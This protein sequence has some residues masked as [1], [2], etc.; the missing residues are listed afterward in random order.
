SVLTARLARN[1]SRNKGLLD[2]I[3]TSAEPSLPLPLISYS[4]AVTDASQP[5][6]GKPPSGVEHGESLA[7]AYGVPAWARHGVISN[8]R[9][10][11]RALTEP[12]PP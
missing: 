6:R 4:L 1:Q 3:G 2:V 11:S 10:R 9:Y 5:Q 8:S 12:P 7:C